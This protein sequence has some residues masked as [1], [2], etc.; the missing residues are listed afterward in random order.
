MT[1]TDK[2]KEQLKNDRLVRFFTPH[3]RLVGVV[4]VLAGVV[5]TVK[6]GSAVLRQQAS[7]SWPNTEGKVLACEYHE[8]RDDDRYWASI[9]YHYEV[10][11]R[12]FK[13]QRVTLDSGSAGSGS[14]SA[15]LA[16][17]ERHP[18]DSAIRVYYDPQDL[19]SAVL[20]TG[21]AVECWYL[22]ALAVLAGLVG[23][24]LLVVGFRLHGLCAAIR[25]R[26][27]RTARRLL[28]K[29][30]DTAEFLEPLA[31][32][33][34]VGDE[35]I[36]EILL[37]HGADKNVARVAVFAKRVGRA[38]MVERLLAK[39]SGP[40]VAP[41]AAEKAVT[42]GP[43]ELSDGRESPIYREPGVTSAGGGADVWFRRHHKRIIVSAAAILF[44][45]SAYQI[46][47]GF[48]HCRGATRRQ[49]WQQTDGVLTRVDMIA[50]I[51]ST[52]SFT[53]S[54]AYEY[55]VSG[56]TH[57]GTRVYARGQARAFR[58]R[59]RADRFLYEN[60]VGQTVRVR[61]DPH[62]PSRAFLFMDSPDVVLASFLWSVLLV[63]VVDLMIIG[64]L[65]FALTR[66]PSE[67]TPND[68]PISLKR[69]LGGVGIA[70]LVALILNGT[71]VLSHRAALGPRGNAALLGCLEQGVSY[72]LFAMF[73]AAPCLLVR[74]IFKRPRLPSLILFLGSGLYITVAA[75]ALVYGAVCQDAL[76]ERLAKRSVALRRAIAVYEKEHGHPP[77]RLANLVPD[78]LDLIPS[79][80]LGTHPEYEYFV[81]KDPTAHLG[82]PWVLYVAGEERFS[83]ADV[84][85]YYSRQNYPEKDS[86]G[87]W[88]QVG[89]CARV[90]MH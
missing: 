71:Y 8:D 3:A 32:A 81:N 20:E 60:K 63:V 11:G 28:A 53:P 36:I 86:N 34:E 57:T 38:A 35:N 39:I 44:I 25:N 65:L 55:D 41:D 46:V 24:R 67:E 58:C 21:V 5:A 51:G 45:M 82:N 17:A 19:G 4:L 37:Q 77:A 26:D 74:A 70:V 16:F 9:T 48:Y 83:E 87:V 61:Y 75:S 89:D 29:S 54:V 85:V 76:F 14:P 42:G 7:T 13:G 78:Q 33:V 12:S 73:L 30:K 23:A 47:S 88:T 50:S 15:A 49:G 6:T 43:A 40:A 59:L 68:E 56:R 22:A 1:P 69:A 84:M 10:G 18:V 27:E 90:D 64:M 72:G 79:T 31:V 52:R 62:D 80:G 2:E 66:K